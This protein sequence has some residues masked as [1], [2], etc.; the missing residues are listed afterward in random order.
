MKL[1]L[2][3]RARKSTETT[4]FLTS[5]SRIRSSGSCII[6]GGV[7][8]SQALLVESSISWC[9]PPRQ[10]PPLLYA[11]PGFHLFQACAQ[12]KSPRFEPFM[13]LPCWKLDKGC[14]LWLPRIFSSVELQWFIM[15]IIILYACY[16]LRICCQWICISSLE[17]LV[18]TF[19][20]FMEPHDFYWTTVCTYYLTKA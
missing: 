7:L 15:L 17:L 11:G 13:W 12:Q 2:S 9:H 6:G 19:P 14:L 20:P 10:V 16:K 18:V 5:Y 8:S 4:R 1:Y 3:P